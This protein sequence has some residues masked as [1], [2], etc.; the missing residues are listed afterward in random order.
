[1]NYAVMLATIVPFLHGCSYSRSKQNRNVPVDGRMIIE[2]GFLECS[3]LRGS[4]GG[5]IVSL[6]IQ[7]EAEE[8]YSLVYK[9]SH[10]N[11]VLDPE[12]DPKPETWHVSGVPCF[13][14]RGKYPFPQT[15][16]THVHADDDGEERT[17]FIVSQSYH[18][19]ALPQPPCKDSFQMTRIIDRKESNSDWERIS[20]GTRTGC[21]T[22]SVTP[23]A[24]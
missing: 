8:S 10:L 13:T 12:P 2:R 3:E 1:M 11:G 7:R 20:E 17:T 5:S 15:N 18:C 6:E 9:V 4:G 19:G 14:I 23:A 16:C 21:L 22:A 24:Q